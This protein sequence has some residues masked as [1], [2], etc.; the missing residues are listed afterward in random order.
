[1]RS[2]TARLLLLPRLFNGFSPPICECTIGGQ[3]LSTRRLQS[4]R[5]PP[6][7]RRCSR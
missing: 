4:V 5:G 6:T 7:S 1:M 3:I 2:S